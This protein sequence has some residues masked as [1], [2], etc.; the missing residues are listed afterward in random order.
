MNTWID[1]SSGLIYPLAALLLVFLV[2]RVLYRFHP[3]TKPPGL[4]GPTNGRG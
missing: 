1:G 2:R 4:R 3:R